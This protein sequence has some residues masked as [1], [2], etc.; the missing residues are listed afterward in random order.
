V[1][2]GLPVGYFSD[3]LTLRELYRMDFWLFKLI[4][5]WMSAMWA[6]GSVSVPP[7]QLLWA[8]ALSWLSCAQPQ[9]AHRWNRDLEKGNVIATWH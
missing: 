3:I 8:T 5:S 7:R 9:F 2:P 6:C 1:K 4:I